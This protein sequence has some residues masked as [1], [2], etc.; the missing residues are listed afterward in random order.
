MCIRDSAYT[1]QLSGNQAEYEWMQ[2]RHKIISDLY[3]N[4]FIMMTPKVQK[5]QG[6]K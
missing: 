4:A 6:A 3:D 2:A 5:Q 1:A